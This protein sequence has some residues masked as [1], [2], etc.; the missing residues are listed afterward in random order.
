MVEFVR[1]P[2]EVVQ[3]LL[4]PEFKTLQTQLEGVN[5]RLDS[6]NGDMDH[7]FE[8]V[9]R[10][11][12]QHDQQFER[13]HTE[14]LALTQT[15]ARMDGKLGILVNHV[16]DYKEA[17]RPSVRVEALERQVGQLAERSEGAGPT[18]AASGPTP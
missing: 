15:V 16:V 13:V 8:Q 14:I 7:R 12:E 17:V 10:R 6:L 2:R 18:G 11:F 4:V 9:E 5:Q 1:G 3:E